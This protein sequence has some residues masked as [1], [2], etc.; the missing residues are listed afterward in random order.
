MAENP[1][2]YLGKKYA[3]PGCHSQL[4]FRRAP[5]RLL[6]TCPNCR[7]KIRLRDR[8]SAANQDELLREAIDSLVQWKEPDDVPYDYRRDPKLDCAKETESGIW[9]FDQ[10]WPEEAGDVVHE[11]AE[12][13]FN[14]EDT[15]G[16]VLARKAL[17][18]GEF[19]RV[20]AVRTGQVEE[21]Q[22]V[23]HWWSE[24][25]PHEA[26]I[27]LLE[28]VVVRGLNRIVTAK[29]FITRINR[30]QRKIIEQ[31]KHLEFFVDLAIDTRKPESKSNSRRR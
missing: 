7:R 5:T 22:I 26:K 24:V 14:P 11:D 29:N 15:Y 28:R 20:T 4:K 23:G 30:V 9:K 27:G 12:V 3:C 19:R 13:L 10:P 21:M 31:K 2:K 1:S 6:Q 17:F 25:Q 18:E 8:E 16:T